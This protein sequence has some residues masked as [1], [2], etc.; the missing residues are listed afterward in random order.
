MPPLD[1]LVAP[2]FAGGARVL[3]RFNLRIALDIEAA[4]MP[5]PRKS[6]RHQPD[7]LRCQILFLRDAQ[8][9]D[10]HR[11][12]S[13]AIALLLVVATSLCAAPTDNA[14]RPDLMPP[15]DNPAHILRVPRGFRAELAAT[16]PAI[17][18]PS[19]IAFDENGRLFTLEPS[20][21]VRLLVATNSDGRFE[22]ISTF[23]DNLS[24]PT[25]LICANGGLFVA[26][27]NRIF[28]L[29][30]T[31]GDGV[32]DI[33]RLVLN[34]PPA[35]S[36]KNIQDF[37][38][39][40]DNR[41]VA[42]GA[43]F[44]FD[45]RTLQVSAELSIGESSLCLDEQGRAILCVPG[46]PFR[47]AMF[48]PRYTARNNFLLAPDPL[49]NLLGLEDAI[50]VTGSCLVYRGLLPTN[51]VR[52]LLIAD[53]E[54]HSIHSLG[55]QDQHLEIAAQ[56][57]GADF[58]T[59]DDPEFAPRQMVAGPGGI[60]IVDGQ[61]GLFQAGRIWRL[62]PESSVW[63]SPNFSKATTYDLVANLA[64]ADSWRRDTVA[65]LLCERPDRAAVPLL[66]S[67]LRYAKIPEARLAAL[68]SLG[69]LGVLTEDNIGVALQDGDARVR[70]RGILLSEKFVKNRDI[71]PQIFHWLVLAAQDPSEWVRYQLAFTLGEISNNEKPSLLAGILYGDQGNLWIQTAVLSSLSDGGASLFV[72]LAS[73]P[74]FRA[75]AYGPDFLKKVLNLVGVEDQ[76][77]DVSTVLR[78]IE[79]S[80]FQHVLVYPW[81]SD[82]SD[83]LRRGGSSLGEADPDNKL[84][85]FYRSA[86]VNACND[87]APVNTR[88]AGLRLFTAANNEDWDAANYLLA[89][90]IPTEP[91]EVQVGCIRAV[92]RFNAER[93]ATLLIQRR[94]A[95][96]PSVRGEIVAALLTRTNNANALL[97]ALER[98]RVLYPSDFSSVQVNYLRTYGDPAIERRAAN[99]FGA[100]STVGVERKKQFASALKLTGSADRG[101]SLFDTR[102]VVCHSNGKFGPPLAYSEKPNHEKLLSDIVDPN[103]DISPG[104]FTYVVDLHTGEKLTGLMADPGAAVALLREPD[105]TELL[106][107]R[108]GRPFVARE[109]WSLMPE[110]VAAGLSP[111]D[112]ADLIEYVSSLR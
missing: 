7:L 96:T 30:D 54:R 91:V 41:I 43:G 68:Q 94:P 8:V 76:P 98:G 92:A 112:M 58:L 24:S 23:A 62:A 25:A 15:A 27:G 71:S 53:P 80:R 26:A 46:Q 59:S 110:E 106:L 31:N 12:L 107:P 18:N 34:G 84:A 1:W 104:Y 17:G 90:I 52:N 38:W 56:K 36:G 13:R 73:D 95:L 89:L 109:N 19:A 63:A 88:M 101:H 21:E 74:A 108:E 70:A 40:S 51:Y 44:S 37:V 60:Y 3:A 61:A 22:A 5:R 93:L 42:V 64:S 99:I 102:C 4:K 35:N 67:V 81:L 105:G 87:S 77:G 97:T 66:V 85:D 83:G 11:G 50:R 79:N 14:S 2:L 78:F 48:D 47:T 28:F 33:N 20:G 16:S 9:M 100:Q 29:Q 39:R 69:N 72:Q 49:Q 82:L 57:P 65:R 55:L 32:A 10:V 86:F 6:G 45:P 111:Q 103:A 75:S